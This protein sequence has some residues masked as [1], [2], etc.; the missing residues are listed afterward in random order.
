MPKPL[1]ALADTTAAD[2]RLA[3]L[4]QFNGS[5]YTHRTYG[6]Y[7]NLGGSRLNQ[8]TYD[9]LVVA[10]IVSGWGSVVFT[11][12]GL[13]AGLVKSSAHTHDGLDVG[14]VQTR[15]RRTSEIWDLVEVAFLC[16]V[17]LMI[18]GTTEDDIADGMVPHAHGVMVGA[19]HAHPDARAQLY[20]PRYG[21]L[22]AGGAGLAGLPTADWWGPKIPSRPVEWAD[23][24][25]NPAN[26]W[27]P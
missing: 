27:R 11:Q 24:R 9:A 21:V 12:G 13:N 14:D 3:M 7:G 17:V 25:Y 18:R 2:A 15:G 22:A 16:G 26:G 6:D 4:L 5:K 23:S 8:R 20:N 1:W 10:G 19:Q